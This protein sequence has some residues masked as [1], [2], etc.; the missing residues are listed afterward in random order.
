[1]KK[2]LDNIIYINKTLARQLKEYKII[3]YNTNLLVG[4]LDEI[5]KLKKKTDD[6]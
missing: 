3:N 4:E 5:D 2:E 1:M 6:M